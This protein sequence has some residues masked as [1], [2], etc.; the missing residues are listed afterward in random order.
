[1]SPSV[2]IVP[3]HQ[4]LLFIL[5]PIQNQVLPMY[6][7]QWR[8]WVCLRNEAFGG[9]HEGMVDVRVCAGCMPPLCV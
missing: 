4:L 3:E 5:A 7:Y 6:C 8:P 1:M 2:D 9:M